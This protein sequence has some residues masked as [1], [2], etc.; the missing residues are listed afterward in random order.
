MHFARKATSVLVKAR[1]AKS[2]QESIRA[3]LEEKINQES[4]TVKECQDAKKK[5]E[6][7][8]DSASKR[9]T[10][11]EAALNASKSNTDKR[12][13]NLQID[14]IRRFTGFYAE[15]ELEAA[16]SQR[17]ESKKEQETALAR[18]AER[19]EDI[20]KR[21]NQIPGEIAD[22]TI[23]V[24]NVSR[25]LEDAES[26]L[27]EYDSIFEQIVRICE[28]YSHESTAAFTGVLRDE[29]RRDIDTTEAD[30]ATKKRKLDSLKEKRKAAESGYLHILP[31]I[32]AYVN[33]TGLNP[34]TGEEYI[35][36]LIEAGTVSVDRAEEILGTYPE[37][38]YALLFNNEKDIKRLLSAGNIEWLPAVV[39][40]FTMAQ[41]DH[42]FDGTKEAGAFLTAH[43]KSFFA[44]R[45]GYLTA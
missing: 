36:G 41:I 39:P 45:E 12:V 4:A 6:A 31:E 28:K 29:I 18:I 11:A 2:E 14:V 21:E 9:Y 7:A 15:E 1:E 8:R 13:A 3:E 20:K 10:E 33:S 38:A 19:F 42:I 24:N 17:E 5:S 22:L 37:M 34:T 25:S 16:K 43:D 23:N 32:M 35:C 27:G 26:E 44:D 30:I 40:L